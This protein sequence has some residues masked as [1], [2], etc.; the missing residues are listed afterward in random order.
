MDRA[1]SGKAGASP[2][3]HWP[4]TNESTASTD[5]T[6]LKGTRVSA[7]DSTD[8]TDV[9]KD[10]NALGD[11]PFRQR[12]RNMAHLLRL[13]LGLAWE[14]S[15][16]MAGLLFGLILVQSA[17][18][19]LQLFL[20]GITID[21]I[22]GQ[23]D[24]GGGARF[25]STTWILVT[26]ATIMLG[27]LIEPIRTY[28]QTMLGDRTTIHTGDRLL[29]ATNRWHGVERFENPKTADDIERAGG[30]GVNVGVDLL[31]QG[32]PFIG[33][34]L[35]AV[36]LSITLAGLHPLIPVLLIV[37]TVPQLAG[38][39][40]FQDKVYS[41]LAYQ[42]PRARVLEYTHQLPMHDREARDFRL[43]ELGDRTLERYE[44]IWNEIT[45]SL[46]EVR[47]RLL[48][49]QG[50]TTALAQIASAAAIIFTIWRASRG[51]LSI[52]Q[53][54]LYTGAIAMLNGT[55]ISIGSAL[56]YIP[57][58][59]AFLP[60]MRRVLDA[61]PDLPVPGRP[62]SLQ[63]P[64]ASGIAFEDVTFTYPAAEGPVLRHVSFTLD[65]GE[66]VALV[67]HNGAGKTTVIKLLL[68]LYDP[69][70]GRITL[71]GVDLRDYDPAEFR[72]ACGVIFQDFGRYDFTARENIAIGDIN[73]PLDDDTLRDALAKSGADAVVETL[74]DGLDA[75]LGLRF[76]GRDLSG[77]E[78]QKI[79]LA[80][81]FVR[82][83]PILIL[84]E[85]TSA[86][87]VRAE[88]EVYQ[89]FAALTR[90]RATMLISHR[91]S[92]V[93]MADRILVLDGSTIADRG[94][95]EEL[96]RDNGTY[97]RLYTAQARHYV[98]NEAPEAGEPLGH[99]V[100]S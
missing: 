41:H 87:D 98:D 39:Y 31:M 65:P 11:L 37:A 28:V 59:L 24:N 46:N 26:A 77:G 30:R 35:T 9:F 68:R 61:P 93:R 8:S 43:F 96:M 84:D 86:L 67:G 56:G 38:L 95:H 80:R 19:P 66:S 15:P 64:L 60:A 70:S 89:R 13:G 18:A 58:M 1:D 85:P 69:D 3:L 23:T 83:A 49:R 57:R 71:D 90:D 51:E 92:T 54:T 53:V 17:L 42:T 76:G 99:A 63:L 74:P 75:M 2:L 33:F 22:I 12:L 10:P 4:H 7:T 52:G 79:A 27:Q 62:V 94:T 78:W 73:T 97:A 50:G 14:S 81:A 40:Q 44:L 16:P 82:D 34:V 29:E 55:L 100:N 45:D 47:Q 32:G 6:W 21:S 91:F 48:R 36:T 20:T 25:G 88:Y 5:R 72:K